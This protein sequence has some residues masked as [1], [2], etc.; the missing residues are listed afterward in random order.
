MVTEE[1]QKINVWI[2]GSLWKQIGSL[3]YESPTKA[4][5][6]AFEALVLQETKGSNQ[7]A[8]G[9][10]Q[11]EVRKLQEEIGRYQEKVKDLEARPDPV[12]FAQLQA[13]YDGL[14]EIIKVYKH[15]D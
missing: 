3:G 13:R 2:P 9:S 4:T 15:F 8:L 7:E 10:S 11:E 5:I 14:L 6:A 1:K 12:T